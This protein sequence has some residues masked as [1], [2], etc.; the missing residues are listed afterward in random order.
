MKISS[1]SFQLIDD[2]R[3]AIM[4]GPGTGVAPFRG[5]ILERSLNKEKLNMLFFGCRNRKKDAF[6]EQDLLN[7]SVN[8][9]YI[10]AYS[11]DQ[12]EKS[13]VQ[14]KIVEHGHLVWEWISEKQARIYLA[15]SAKQVPEQVSDAL[16]SVFVTHGSMSTEEAD[17]YLQHLER[18]KRFQRETWS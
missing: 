10:P 8:L 13:Y 2:N 14:H 17:Q 11:R 18:T 16:K 5:W 1:S 9:I 3:P 7:E 15:G 6:V 12:E 4:I